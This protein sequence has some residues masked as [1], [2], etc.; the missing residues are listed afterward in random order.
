MQLFSKLRLSLFIGLSSYWLVA[1]PVIASPYRPGAGF[2]PP[3]ISAISTAALAIGGAVLGGLLL[4]VMPCVFPILSLKALALAKS[5]ESEAH[6][7]AEAVSYTAGVVLVC[8]A[9]GA[10]LLALRAGGSAAGW[11]FQLQNP[12]VIGTLILLMV[13]VALNLSGLFE[14][15]TPRFAGESGRA[16]A[17]ATGA[18]AAFVATPCSGPFMGAAL[19]AALVLPTAAALLIFMGLGLGISLPFLLLG[20]VPAL[21]SR[22]PRPGAW[23]GSLRRIL[24][25]PMW[26]TALALLWVLGRQTGVDGMALALG[27]VLLLALGLWFAGRQQSAGRNGTGVAAIAFVLACAG[28]LT[29]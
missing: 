18:L 16:G 26:L 12:R 5:T 1:L 10:L 6:A 14:L 23:M 29:I 25:I 27:T 19:G 4:N 3:G 8:T 21:R 24:A 11:A 13:G 22:L 7:R 9:L 28:A 2:N 17:F 20:F 15:P